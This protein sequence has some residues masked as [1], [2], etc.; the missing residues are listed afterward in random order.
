M[1]PQS[2]LVKKKSSVKYTLPLT[3]APA[4]ALCHLLLVCVS[5]KNWY[6]SQDECSCCFPLPF[7]LCFVCLFL[8]NGLIYCKCN[9]SEHKWYICQMHGF[10]H[11]CY[12]LDLKHSTLSFCLKVTRPFPFISP[13]F[14]GTKYQKNIYLAQMF[15]TCAESALPTDISYPIQNQ[16]LDH[17]G[18]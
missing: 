7:F 5:E 11:T 15:G 1:A 8:Q 2:I 10:Y 12:N 13:L 17:G 14:Y 16:V 18:K 4:V 9:K 6:A 3:L